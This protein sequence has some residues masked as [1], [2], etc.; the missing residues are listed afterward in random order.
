[1]PSNDRLTMAEIAER[2]GVSLPTVSL[3]SRDRPGVGLETRQRIMDVAKN[4][5]YSAKKP[6]LPY[7][8]ALANNVSGPSERRGNG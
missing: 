7:T 4:L 1:V 5:G 8:P 6:V 3:I 2:S